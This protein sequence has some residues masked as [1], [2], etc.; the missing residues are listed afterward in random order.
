MIIASIYRFIAYVALPW[1]TGSPASVYVY[2]FSIGLA[3]ILLPFFI[4]VALVKIGN[5]SNDSRKIGA[6]Q[7]GRYSKHIID[8]ENGSSDDDEK[9]NSSD[10]LKLIW[11]HSLPTGPFLHLLISFCF[12]FPR[13]FTEAQLIRHGFLSKASLWKTD[14]DPILSG[15]NGF[16]TT[17]FGLLRTI[18]AS[19]H[20]KLFSVHEQQIGQ[21]IIRNSKSLAETFSELDDS[22]RFSLEFG[23][24]I[25]ALGMLVVR[26]PSVFWRV[27]K[28]FSALFTF[29]LL[30]NSLQTII[31]VAA[32]QVLM[33]V[34]ICDPT[35]LLIRFRDSASTSLNIYHLCLLFVG[36]LLLLNFGSLA[37]YCH[38]LMKY[39]EFRYART[40]LLQAKYNT[41]GTFSHISYLLAIGVFFGLCLTVGPIFYET[42]LVYCGTLSIYGLLFIFSTIIHFT[43]W[44]MI[45]FS[46]A[47]KNSWTFEFD[48]FESDKA[49]LD[50]AGAH[51][52]SPLIV[53]SGGKLFKVHET[54]AKQAIMNFVRNNIQQNN[55]SGLQQPSML[56]SGKPSHT[57]SMKSFVPHAQ[58]ARNA[59]LPNR[60]HFARVSTRTTASTVA[61]RQFFESTPDSDCESEYAVFQRAPQQQQPPIQHPIQPAPLPAEEDIYGFQ[62]MFNPIQQTIPQPEV[63]SPAVT[64]VSRFTFDRHSQSSGI[65]SNGSSSQS[66]I[67]ENSNI[68]SSAS[69]ESLT[70]RLE[71]AATAAAK[72]AL[73]SLNLVYE[74]EMETNVLRRQHVTLTDFV[75]HPDYSKYYITDASN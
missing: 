51:S 15:F 40:M 5:F 36:Y 32:F 39:R 8:E 22:G 4:V 10:W 31:S 62:F 12:L 27:H 28:P 71:M 63:I 16:S 23:N 74:P 65:G 21:F 49:L 6:F 7:L 59:T 9:N 64:N 3:I 26:Y 38:G 54:A 34:F 11:R 72:P 35:H 70:Q 13:F 45:W 66:S 48:D 2:M 18:T 57:M 52:E 69:M 46:L 29:Y 33:K 60:K 50:K 19:E 53:I 1:P 56:A 20:E 67:E 17:F 30:L 73:K 61:K 37:L 41:Q 44:A 25:F 47:I 24:F 58:N 42:V 14:L 68:K 75:D 43:A 55:S